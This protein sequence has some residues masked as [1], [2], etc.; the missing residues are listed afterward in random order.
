MN[1]VTLNGLPQQDVVLWNA[2]ITGYT[3]HGLAKEALH[4]FF[5]MLPTGVMPDKVTFL[6]ILGACSHFGLVE[7]GRNYFASMS[8]DYGISPDVEHCVCMIDL[9]GRA[10]Q[11]DEAEYFIQSMPD[12]PTTLSFMAF[13]GSCHSHVEVERGVDAAKYIFEL[14]PGNAAPYVMLSNIYVACSREK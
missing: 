6:G 7:K 8:Q 2:L 9:L 5:E 12:Q 13:L 14:D 1:A 11:F 10:G 3:Q 4:L